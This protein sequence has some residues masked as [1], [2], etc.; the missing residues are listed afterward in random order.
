MSNAVVTAHAEGALLGAGAVEEADR[1]EAGTWSIRIRQ[2]RAAIGDNRTLPVRW[3]ALD[4]TYRSRNA[5]TRYDGILTFPLQTAAS[6]PLMAI[7][8]PR[9]TPIGKTRGTAEM[10]LR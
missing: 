8:R 1:A 5:A 3:T 6:L 10:L 9:Y 7:C 2:A 4:R